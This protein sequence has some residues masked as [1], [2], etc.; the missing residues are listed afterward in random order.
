[1]ILLVTLFLTFQLI[2]PLGNAIKFGPDVEPP[3]EGP[4]WGGTLILA[5]PK[6]PISFNGVANFWDLHAFTQGQVLQSL[7]YTKSSQPTVRAGALCESWEISEDRKVWTF[8]LRDNITWSDG[9]PFTS[10]DVEYFYNEIL[11]PSI[12]PEAGWLDTFE[13]LSCEATDL[14]TVVFTFNK[15]VIGRSPDY[16]FRWGHGSTLVLPKHRYEGTDVATNP[17]NWNPVGTGPFKVV[18]WRVNEYII[19]EPSE[20]YWGRRPY[21]DRVIIKFIPDEIAALMALEAGEIDDAHYRIPPAE[22]ERLIK[23]PD[24]LVD[25]RQGGGTI[26]ATWNF[27]DECLEKHPWVDDINVRK[28]MRYAIDIDAMVGSLTW[29]LSEHTETCVATSSDFHNPNVPQDPY[30]PDLAEQLLDAAGYPRGAD[31]IRF[32]FKMPLYDFYT[33]I[34][35]VLVQYWKEIGVECE[36]YPIEA[37]TFFSRFENTNQEDFPL[38]IHHMGA[39]TPR[40]QQLYSDRRI[41]NQNQGNYSNPRVDELLD[42]CRESWTEEENRPYYYEIQQIVHDDYE[43]IPLWN[44]FRVKARSTEFWGYQWPTVTF[45]LKDIWWVG[46]KTYEEYFG[47]PVTPV[48]PTI[49]VETIEELI[50]AF[51]VMT[52]DMTDLKSDLHTQRADVTAIEDTL[53]TISTSVSDMRIIAYA[54]IILA[55]VAIALPFVRKR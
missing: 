30:D 42:L 7:L 1:M 39:S 32:S 13:L 3:V 35:E 4:L 33:Y 47:V 11:W 27:R 49:P 14:F 20:T 41:G 19:L 34:A 12:T 26:R 6:D 24:I 48:E 25:P 10:A 21:L 36:L 54:G 53:E 38:A 31:G 51:D 37:T 50:D 44:T 2:L 52:G 15:S 43:Q 29:G 8:H 18:D 5:W 23:M 17:T 28:A 46:G 9:V 16:G 45:N 40:D 22:S 55:I